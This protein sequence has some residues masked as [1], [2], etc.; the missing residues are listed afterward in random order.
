MM[1][2]QAIAHKKRTMF[3]FNTLEINTFQ[4]LKTWKVLL[5]F[6]FFTG[7]VKENAVPAY[8]Y[9]PAF[10]LTTK[11]GEG[12]T[13]QKITDAW[14]YVDG[15]INGVFQMPITLPVVELGKCQAF[16]TTALSQILSFILFSI[17]IKLA[18]I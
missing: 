3:G 7:C 4:A 16:A 11:T 1:N 17:P 14:V 12:T 18:P 2:F 9:I 13:S 10:S 6:I 5:L 15:Q 8:I